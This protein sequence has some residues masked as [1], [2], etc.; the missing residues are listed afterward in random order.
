[1]DTDTTSSQDMTEISHLLPQ[2][3]FDLEISRDLGI[4]SSWTN[5]IHHPF[6][7]RRVSEKVQ[8]DGDL[9]N[10]HIT[11]LFI[12]EDI[13]NLP[14]RDGLDQIDRMVRF[15]ED[16]YNFVYEKPAADRMIQYSIHNF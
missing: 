10:F 15:L 2:E 8:F 5:I 11:W 16:E 14:L 6:T 1:M 12:F 7:D 13:M 3:M 4:W 9:I